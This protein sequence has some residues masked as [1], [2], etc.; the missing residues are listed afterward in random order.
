MFS[1]YVSSGRKNKVISGLDV[2]HLFHWKSLFIS[3]IPEHIDSPRPHIGCGL[4]IPSRL[5][6][7]P[8]TH[9]D[10]WN[11]IWTPSTATNEFLVAIRRFSKVSF[12]TCDAFTPA[13]VLA[14]VLWMSR[15][16]W[17]LCSTL[18]R[19]LAY[20]YTNSPWISMRKVCFFY[21]SRITLRSSVGQSLPCRQ[22][23]TSTYPLNSFWMTESCATCHR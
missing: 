5:R 20:T 12:S 13:T 19:P 15:N 9:S 21:K 8:G 17:T 22:H 7:R 6:T 11:A 2:A 18:F 14:R 16:F 10:S 23:C 1:S 4:R 3:P